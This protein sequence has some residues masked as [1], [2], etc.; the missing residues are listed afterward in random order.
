MTVKEYLGQVYKIDRRIQITLA[1]AEKMRASVIYK[2][3]T[4]SGE[5]GGT[6]ASDRIGEAIAKTVDYE[7]R[8]DELVDKLVDMRLEIERAIQSVDDVVQREILE[9]RYLLFQS[10]DSRYD[11][12]TGE[13]I[14]GIAESMGYSERQIFRLHGE[15]LKKIKMSADVSECQF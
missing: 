5:G 1:K 7:R 13:Y 8:A 4:F 12:R 15:A 2:S 14:K 6:P 3:P 11:A 10:W 9:R